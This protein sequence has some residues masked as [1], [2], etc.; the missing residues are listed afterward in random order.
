MVWDKLRLE[1]KNEQLEK[2]NQ[3]LASFAYV[4]SH[5]LQQPLRKIQSFSSRILELDEDNFS[6]KTKDYFRRMQQSANRMRC[7]IDNLLSFSK[8]NT[9]ERAF[10]KTDVNAMI[11]QPAAHIAR[12][13]SLRQDQINKKIK[14]KLETPF[15]RLRLI[16][17]VTNQRTSAFQKQNVSPL[18]LRNA[19]TF[20]VSTNT[21]C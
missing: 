9:S 21:R 14:G 17:S 19:R 7:L 1:E 15:R 3:E 20:R 13:S 10:K 8:I 12:P 2:M 18:M 5:D 11:E 16:L 6:D 4:S